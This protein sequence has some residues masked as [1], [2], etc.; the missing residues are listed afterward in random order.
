[1]KIYTKTG[2]KG[3]TSLFGGQRVSK[4][5]LRIDAYGTLDELLS[6]IGL[7]RDQEVNKKIKPLLIEIQDRLFTIGAELATAPEKGKT[8]KH[9]DLYEEDITILENAIDE[10]NEQLEPMRFFV[11]PGGHQAVSFA[12]LARCV[13]RKAERL[14]IALHQTEPVNDLILQYVNR[15]SDYLFT[16]S[17][18]MS[19]QLNAE[20]IP[21]KPRVKK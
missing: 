19:K 16:L 4:A 18:Y 11:L 3:E 9:P 1:M 8:R 2:D 6:Y 13:C 12:H 10:M 14:I 21:W 15:L 20:E 17:R 5:N 7:L